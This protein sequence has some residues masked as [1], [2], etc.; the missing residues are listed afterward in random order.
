M[1]QGQEGRGGVL[2]HGGRPA[3]RLSLYDELSRHGR[4][5]VWRMYDCS[6]LAYRHLHA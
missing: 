2:M 5:V 6:S 3:L 4:G 1:A